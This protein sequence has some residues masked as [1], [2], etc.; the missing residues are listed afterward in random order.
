MQPYYPARRRRMHQIA[1]VIG[2]YLVCLFSLGIFAGAGAYLAVSSEAKLRSDLQRSG[3]RVAGAAY[4]HAS[5]G[6]HARLRFKTR[7][8]HTV[9]TFYDSWLKYPEYHGIRGRISAEF[10]PVDVIYDPENPL[11]AI[12]A[13]FTKI[14]DID[15][16]AGFLDVFS[17]FFFTIEILAA[18]LTV[19]VLG[20][21][22]E[23]LRSYLAAIY[24]Q[25]NLDYRDDMR[26]PS[27]ATGFSDRRR[28]AERQD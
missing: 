26:L 2:W 5:A 12:P 7:E 17:R 14:P 9:A 27:S 15:V 22:R 4:E 18:I 3:V 19:I 11:R 28:G 1:T 10:L 8:G 21:R 16:H 23:G 20:A 6:Y 24:R 13:P 25:D